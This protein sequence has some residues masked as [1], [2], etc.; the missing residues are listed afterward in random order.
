MGIAA[1]CVQLP[2]NS[3]P[4]ELKTAF[5]RLTRYIAC[6]IRAEI[7][8]IEMPHSAEGIGTGDPK[9]KISCFSDLGS[10]GM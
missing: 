5:W 4:T 3:G 10:I 7:I 6:I 1:Y 9:K 8:R 2:A